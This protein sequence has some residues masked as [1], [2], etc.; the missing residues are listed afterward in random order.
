MDAQDQSQRT[1]ARKLRAGRVVPFLGAGANLL[2]R[3]TG[4][5]FE[6]GRYL[7]SGQ[8]LAAYLAQRFEYPD[9]DA[10]ELIR[11]SQWISVFLGDG[12]LYEQ[13]RAVFD[14]D[15]PPTELHRFLAELPAL[16]RQANDPHYQLIFT[17]NYDDALERA[18]DC[19][20]EPYD[21]LTY[22]TSSGTDVGRLLHTPPGEEPRLIEASNEYHDLQPDER[23]VIVK[24]HGAVDR[25]DPDRDSV[26]ITEDDYL[27]FLRQNDLNGLLPPQLIAKLKTSNFLFLG[28]S[29]RDW[30][31]RVLL[32]SFWS[33]QKR[34]FNSWAIQRDPDPIDQRYWSRRRV[35]ILDMPIEDYIVGLRA[36]VLEQ[37]DEA[38]LP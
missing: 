10:L 34:G 29:L 5:Q 26:V 30:N 2:G 33:A 25:R 4:Q 32:H 18:F 12:D 17:T 6:R 3:P 24:I 31:I 37:L 15:Y 13:L 20:G 8:E 23:T 28:Y 14:A 21:L 27:S 16:L 36:A 11:V 19:Q 38:A 7:P 22:T 1:L 9:R 35:E